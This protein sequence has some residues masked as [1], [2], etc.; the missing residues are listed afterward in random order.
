MAATVNFKSAQACAATSSFRPNKNRILTMPIIRSTSIRL[1]LTVI[2][3]ALLIMSVL[4][5]K[6]SIV[7]AWNHD[8]Q[9]ENA[10]LRAPNCFP[11]QDPSKVDNSLPPCVD[12]TLVVTAKPEHTTVDHMHYHDYPTTHRSLTLQGNDGQAQTVGDI[13]EDMWNSLKVGD[14]VS[15]TLWQNKIQ[16][17]S[18]NGYTTPIIDTSDWNHVRA[19]VV[20]LGML[21]IVCFVC[22][23]ILWSPLSCRPNSGFF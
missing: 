18:A 10:Y 5:M 23:G 14:P 13:Y 1:S 15:A 2:F 4:I 17:V 20:P 7:T 8:Q 9:K 3:V 16:E 21:A 12:V 6:K 22:L 11:R 19:T